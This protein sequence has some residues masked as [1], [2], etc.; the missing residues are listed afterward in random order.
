[1]LKA[2]LRAEECSAALGWDWLEESPRGH[3][4]QEAKGWVAQQRP[5]GEPS[6]CAKT[7]P[8]NLKGPCS[9]P[10]GKVKEPLGEKMANQRLLARK[11]A[12][13]LLGQWASAH[14]TWS[15]WSS[16]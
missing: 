16:S 1:M 11:G 6:V 9:C 15:P 2:G 12:W 14:C 3:D 4:G 5:L 10:E 13:E 8:L 7:L